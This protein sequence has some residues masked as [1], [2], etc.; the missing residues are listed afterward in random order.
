MDD[1]TTK[2]MKFTNRASAFF[3]V[4]FVSFV[5]NPK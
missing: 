4:D 2:D 3:F 5:V 1:I